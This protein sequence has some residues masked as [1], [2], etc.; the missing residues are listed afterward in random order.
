LRIENVAKLTQLSRSRCA[1]SRMVNEAIL[2]LVSD[3]SNIL[4]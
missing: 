1:P 3:G 4:D 2:I